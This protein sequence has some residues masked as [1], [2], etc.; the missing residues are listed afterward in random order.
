MVV[1]ACAAPDGQ[2]P[3]APV[4]SS[5]VAS[6]ASSEPESPHFNLEVLLRGEEGFG[7]VRFRQPNDD[8]QIVNLD[9]W[10]RDLAP[11]TNFLLQRAVD[12]TLDGACTSTN[13]LTLGRG[14]VPQVITTDDRGTA[15]EHLFR[16]LSA[17]PP[18]T[19]FDIHFRVVDAKT[20]EVVLTG[21]CYTFT[22]R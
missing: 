13:W 21:E 19:T 14:L 4:G 10:V 8:S 16:N 3:M 20:S 11:N 2:S 6:S 5:A 7:H 17:F 12:R 22:V 18:G 1:T 9:V 15:R